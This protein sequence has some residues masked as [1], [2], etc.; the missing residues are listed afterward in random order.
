MP[1]L[2]PRAAST[3]VHTP[4]HGLHSTLYCASS[5]VHPGEHS[6]ARHVPAVAHARAPPC[7]ARQHLKARCDPSGAAAPAPE[8]ASAGA[9]KPSRP[10]RSATAKFVAHGA[11]MCAPRCASPLL[12]HACSHVVQLSLTGTHD[13]T[14]TTTVPSRPRT[15]HSTPRTGGSWRT[16]GSCSETRLAVR[17]RRP[18]ECACCRH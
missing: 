13:H 8:L 4:V 3:V 5:A 16:A 2:A 10:R 11:Q 18:R 7:G 6:K 12:T 17:P 14:T 15:C 1:A 9:P